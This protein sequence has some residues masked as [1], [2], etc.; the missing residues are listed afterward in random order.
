MLGY[1]WSKTFKLNQSALPSM[2]EI[3][4]GLYEYICSKIETKFGK[5]DEMRIVLLKQSYSGI[6]DHIL[7]CLDFDGAENALTIE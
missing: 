2:K 1:L 3:V 5:L 4:E 6:F 7:K